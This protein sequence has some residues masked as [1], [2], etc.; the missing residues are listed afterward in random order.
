MSTEYRLLSADSH[1]E[2]SPQRWTE[3]VPTIYRDRAPRLVKLANGGDG[4]VVEG[5]PLYVVGLAIA[6]K[7]YERH[8]L[9]GVIYSGSEG[10]G[11]PEQRLKEQQYDGVDGEIL[12]TSASNLTFWRGI[13]ND[14]A[15]LAVVRAYNSFLA[16]EYC[17]VDRDRLVAMGAIPTQSV[18]AAVAELEYCANA[19]LKGVML[20]AFPS[21]KSFPSPEDDRFYAAAL[22]LNMPLTVHVGMQLPDGPLFRYDRDPGE[23][24][25]GGDPI[26]V[27]T[28]FAGSSGLNA[29]QLLLSGVFD[30]Y[31]RL[32][33]YWAETQMG[34]I[35]YFYEQLDDVY[36]RSKHW[37]DRYFGFKPLKRQPS[38]YIRDHCYWGFIYDRI[39]LRLRYDIGVDRIMWGNDF[40]HSAGD[41]PHSKQVIEDIFSGVPEDERQKILVDNAVNYFHLH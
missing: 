38:E 36:K 2:I 30:R 5:R 32:Q 10:A 9:T 27:L 21:G 31:P 3:R 22:D 8:Q 41:W 11:T 16:E 34:W 24:A 23:V 28:R 15:Y 7:P 4:I 25:F 33:I 37:M 17:A 12:Y 1:L 40:P 18:E 14:E 6:G 26:R 29:V 19:G 39:G 20:N 13:K 35:P